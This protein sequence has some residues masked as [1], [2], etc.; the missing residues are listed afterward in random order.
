M[1]AC[2][3]WLFRVLCVLKASTV[4]WV[5]GEC[6]PALL[7]ADAGHCLR[8]ENCFVITHNTHPTHTQ[9]DIPVK[10]NWAALDPTPI[11]HYLGLASPGD[12]S[13]TAPGDTSPGRASTGDASR[14]SS[15]GDTTPASPG[16]TVTNMTNKAAAKAEKAAADAVER[17]LAGDARWGALPPFSDRVLVFVRGVG[18]AQARG[19]YYAG[20][21]PWR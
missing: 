14:P 19:Q 2:W 15:P 3:G 18:V 9:F 4:C 13:V 11:R 16:G 8:L 17:S 21:W 10:V 7:A 6:G 20:V 12:A 5:V 1:L